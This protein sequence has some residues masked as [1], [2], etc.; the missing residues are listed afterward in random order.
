MMCQAISDIMM[1]NKMVIVIGISVFMNWDHFV[2]MLNDNLVRVVMNWFMCSM[3]FLNN[4]VAALVII[5]MPV[6]LSNWS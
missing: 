6:M 5:S 2:V 3:A 1:V 4:V